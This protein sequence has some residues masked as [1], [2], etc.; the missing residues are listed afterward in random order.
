MQETGVF[1][2]EVGRAVGARTSCVARLIMARCASAPVR[3]RLH[4][5][6]SPCTAAEHAP[7]SAKM[8]GRRYRMLLPSPI[9]PAMVAPHAP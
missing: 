1:A 8:H 9:L 6:S 7:F 2:K 5:L 4:V 3:H